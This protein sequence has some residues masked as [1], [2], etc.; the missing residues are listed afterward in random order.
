MWEFKGLEYGK[1]PHKEYNDS[2]NNNN[3]KKISMFTFEDLKPAKEIYIDDLIEE[4]LQFEFDMSLMR[5]QNA[6]KG[7]PTWQLAH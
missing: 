1:M 4:W 5:W 6:V 2:N 7:I 3:P